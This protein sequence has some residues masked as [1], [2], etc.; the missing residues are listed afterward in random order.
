MYRHRAGVLEVFL[1]H[2]GAPYLYRYLTRQWCMVDSQG[3]TKY[4]NLQ[5]IE[6]YLQYDMYLHI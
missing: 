6:Y 5:I 1:V 2:F 3:D 4:E